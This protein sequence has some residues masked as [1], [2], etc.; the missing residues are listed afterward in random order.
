MNGLKYIPAAITAGASAYM[1]IHGVTGW[2]WFLFATLIF[3]VV[4]SEKND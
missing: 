1:A 4:A 2:G 3:L